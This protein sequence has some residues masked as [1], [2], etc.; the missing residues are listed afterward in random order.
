MKIER[1]L[2]RGTNWLGDAVMTTP[3]LERLRTSFPAAHIALLAT[4]LTARLF[5]TSPFVNEVLE[6]RRR[7]EGVKAFFATVGELRARRFDLAVLFQNAFEAALLAAGGSPLGLGSDSGGS[8]RLPA[9][10]CGVAG[11]KP[12]GGRVPNTGAYDHPG[13]LTDPR[14]QVGLLARAVADLAL[15]L[16]YIVGPD[17]LDGGVV[18]MPLGDAHAVPVHQLKVAYFL[19]ERG[20]DVTSETAHTV[21]ATAQALSRAG[22]TVEGTGHRDLPSHHHAGPA[23]GARDRIPVLNDGPCG[24]DRRSTHAAAHQRTRGV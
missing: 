8:I 16:P 4:G 10:Y 18:P 14:T 5:Q 20:A 2:V 19:E 3:A 23:P 22:V 7:E 17:N 24:G 15:G 13:G 21:G 6:Y 1:I 9:H 11:I 12:T